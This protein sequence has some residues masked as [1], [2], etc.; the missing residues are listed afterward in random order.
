MNEAG[1]AQDA[2]PQED[3]LDTSGPNEAGMVIQRFLAF[4]TA[5]TL[6]A[7]A[8]EQACLAAFERVRK[9]ARRFERL[10][11]RTLPHSDISRLNR[12]KGIP[13]EISRDTADLLE[14][15]LSYCADSDG[16]FDIT[17]GAAV[18]LWD[19]RRATIPSQDKL[20]EAVAHVDWRGVRVWEECGRHFSQLVDPQAAVDVGGIA[21]GWI[22]DRFTNALVEA[23]LENFLIN[24]GGNV[25]A[26]GE[27]PGGAAWNIGIRDP[28]NKGAI[29]G[30]VPIR[31]ASTVTSGIYERCCEVNG[32]FYHHILSPETGMPVETDVAGVT[33]VADRSIDAEGYST[34][35]LA[36]GTVRGLA[37]AREHPAIRK[38]IFV[39]HNG[40]VLES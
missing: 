22:A 35:L 17:M 6:Q 19:L 14:C 3:F 16:R 12:A 37:F 7:S 25:V 13:I 26:H 2:I 33:V 36:L 40:D 32:K 24:L 31:N 23:G 30:A 27:K 9:E 5:I 4:N 10:F 39:T 1:I 38:A 11:S 21:K 34:T 8:P 20:R 28:R 18:Q 29:V 15:A